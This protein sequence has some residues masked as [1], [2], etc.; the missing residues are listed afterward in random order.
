MFISYWA[1]PGACVYLLGDATPLYF[2][3]PVLYNTTWDRWPLAEA[4]RAAPADLG[5]WSR[6]LSAQGVR[7]IL[8]NPSEIDRLIRSGWAD[9]LITG[10]A[11]S[12]WLA[13][14]ARLIRQWP[15][16]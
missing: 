8:V 16:S 15:G 14:S 10:H 11:V 4:M 6:A 7:Y 12:D 13:H 9:P 2:S 5:A 1:K 3:V